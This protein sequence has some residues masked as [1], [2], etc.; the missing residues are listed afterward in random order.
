[1]FLDLIK[2]VSF[3]LA[4]VFA[5]LAA[6]GVAD[7]RANLGWLALACFALPFLVEALVSVANG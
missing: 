6:R 5:A 7:G 3:L 2:L 1:M 4:V